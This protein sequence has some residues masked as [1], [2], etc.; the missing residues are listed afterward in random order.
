MGYC[1]VVARPKSFVALDPGPLL[2]PGRT[3]GWV[4]HAGLFF[5]GTMVFA[6]AFMV[7]STSLG[8]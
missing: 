8:A 2:L 5:E 3:E 7:L 6:L 1:L 4:Q